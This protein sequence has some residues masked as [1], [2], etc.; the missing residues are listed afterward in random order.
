MKIIT[1]CLLMA[2]FITTSDEPNSN[3]IARAREKFLR[4]NQAGQTEKA[5]KAAKALYLAGR[6]NPDKIEV[7]DITPY[8]NGNWA[9]FYVYRYIQP[10]IGERILITND[11]EATEA[12]TESIEKFIKK[13]YPGALS[14][15]ERET[16][17]AL[18]NELHGDW[19]MDKPIIVKKLADIPDYTR[20]PLNEEQLK[21]FN[22]VIQTTSTPQ[23]T[24]LM[25]YHELGGVVARHDFKFSDDNKLLQATRSI[26]ATGIGSPGGYCR[27]FDNDRI[28]CSM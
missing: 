27:I 21:L 17:I 28:Y 20:H 19:L 7:C 1:L 8:P 26:I 10:G 22:D 13:V 4:Y 23:Q 25:V 11:G 3:R 18:F 12:D 15:A 16:A 9:T 5:G 14:P 6:K 24:T 2:S